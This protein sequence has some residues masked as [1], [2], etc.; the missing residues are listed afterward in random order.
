[1]NLSLAKGAKPVKGRAIAWPQRGEE[2]R[3]RLLKQIDEGIYWFREANRRVQ[4][5]I[6]RIWTAELEFAKSLARV[7]AAI[8]WCIEALKRLALFVGF[9]DEKEL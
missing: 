2:R 3:A 1:M 5:I 8:L 7:Q 4:E 9:M 6:M